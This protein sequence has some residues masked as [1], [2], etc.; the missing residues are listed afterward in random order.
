MH[1]TCADESECKC[2]GAFQRFIADEL[3]PELGDGWRAPF[4]LANLG[5]RYEDGAIGVAEHHY[6]TENTAGTFKVMI[7]KVSGHV[8]IVDEGDAPRF[9]RMNRYGMPSASCGAL[10]ALMDGK[11]L[12]ALRG[13]RDTFKTNGRDRLEQ[14]LDERVVKPE[15]RGLF[16]AVVNA[17]LQARRVEDAI[18]EHVPHTPTLYLVTTCVTLN[19]PK[20]DTELLC[21]M[22]TIDRRSEKPDSLYIGLGDDPRQYEIRF[23]NGRIRMRDDQFLGE[24]GGSG[25]ALED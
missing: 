2:A 17:S 3:L 15:L 6:A 24:W 7:V 23:E 5:A 10:H 8:A 12:P 25:I 14:I 21:G 11:D 9:G 4:R 19:R 1:I 18:K 22:Y 16:I 13:L 20:A